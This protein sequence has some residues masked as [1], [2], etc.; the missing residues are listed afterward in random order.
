MPGSEQQLIAIL[1]TVATREQARALA[2]ALVERGLVA[3]VQLSAIDSIYRWDGA[4]QHDAEVRLLLKTTAANYATVE[5]AIREAHPYE[6]PAIYAL[7]VVEAFAPYADWV[8]A[9]T[10]L[11]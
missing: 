1:T 11:R 9:G 6:L 10:S 5:A 2:T 4:L 8:R 7:E 3:C